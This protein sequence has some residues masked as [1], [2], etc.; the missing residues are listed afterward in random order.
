MIFTTQLQ[1]RAGLPDAG[2]PGPVLAQQQA[3]ADASK[4]LGMLET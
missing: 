1:H 2:L 4:R 3:L